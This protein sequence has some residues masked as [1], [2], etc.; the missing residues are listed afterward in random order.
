MHNPI[1]D[2]PNAQSIVGIENCI[3]FN[4]I[5]FKYEEDDVIKELIYHQQ[6]T[7]GSFSWA[8]W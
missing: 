2:K 7:Y 3:R 5:S 4:N 1:A 8:I 6:R